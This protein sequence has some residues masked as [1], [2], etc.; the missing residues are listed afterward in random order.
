MVKGGLQEMF[1][2]LSKIL[3]NMNLLTLT[4]VS[5]V[6]STIQIFYGHLKATDGQCSNVDP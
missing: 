2:Q 3:Y 1:L 4:C 5:N 6:V